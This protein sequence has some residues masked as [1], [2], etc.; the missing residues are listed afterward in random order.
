MSVS[1]RCSNQDCRKHVRAPD[2]AV[3][4]KARCPF[5]GTIQIVPTPEPSSPPEMQ[6]GDLR[7]LASGPAVE[8]PG[9]SQRRKPHR[10]KQDGGIDCAR[11]RTFVPTGVTACPT[12]GLPVVQPGARVSA[13]RSAPSTVGDFLASCVGAAG[14]GA[15]SLGVCFKLI[16]CICGINVL[17][18][19]AAFL[20][21]LSSSGKSENGELLLTIGW[22]A[23]S[24]IISGYL[25]RFYMYAVTSSLQ[26]TNLPPTLP[27]FSIPELMLTAL[28]GLGV[29]V[30]YIIPIVTLPLLPLGYLALA[31][32]NDGRAYDLVWAFRAAVKRPGRLAILWVVLTMH[33]VVGL[34]IAFVIYMLAALI[35][36]VVLAAIA[37]SL[38]L[39][40]VGQLV[41]ALPF[42]LV[43]VLLFFAMLEGVACTCFRCVGLLGRCT[44][45][46]LSMLPKRSN[47]L[48]SLGFLAAGIAISVAVWGLVMPAVVSCV[49]HSG[50][51]VLS[52][53]DLLGREQARRAKCK[54]NLRGIGI[55][56]SLYQA[57]NNDCLPPDLA[58]LIPGHFASPGMMVCPATG[59]PPPR[60]EG[61]KLIGEVDYIYLGTEYRQ[62]P[63]WIV[64][65]YEKPANHGGKGANV[66]FVNGDVKWLPPKHLSRELSRSR[67]WQAGSSTR[68]R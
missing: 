9:R 23:V 67:Q 12:C 5:C 49:A 48:K 16:L 62:P 45:E 52:G 39:S 42:A 43:I 63:G 24:L 22:L 65:C 36:S 27:P 64:L 47:T 59:H 14:Y 26:G 55:A 44:P 41:L 17:F 19:I 11:C 61:G 2:T 29:A 53:V 13:A 54:A 32:T 46:L 3:G 58:A 68:P 51:S 30:V 37:K 31:Q 33:I 38:E 7:L 25:L 57:N 1:F 56:C 40:P 8:T 21:G 6:L 4:K 15:K 10:H 60:F 34:I 66:L 18:S 20:I 35:G 28:K 50:S